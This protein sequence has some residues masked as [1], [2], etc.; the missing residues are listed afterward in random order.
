MS[1]YFY[2]KRQKF[3][4]LRLN[5][6]LRFARNDKLFVRGD[7]EDFDFGIRARNVVNGAVVLLLVL[8]A[9][10]VMP[11][12][13]MPSQISRRTCQVF[14]PI[15]AVKTRQSIPFIA[16]IYEPIYFFTS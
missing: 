5:K 7:D 13:L 14:S 9:S 2:A 3:R 1:T 8:S 12:K 11:K 10:I 4:S 6:F 15:P 16:A